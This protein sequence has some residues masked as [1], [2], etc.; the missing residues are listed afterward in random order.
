M[1]VIPHA[2]VIAQTLT[3]AE[4]SGDA[5]GVFNISCKE[6]YICFQYPD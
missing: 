2:S 4:A 6:L 5:G 3:L 1:T